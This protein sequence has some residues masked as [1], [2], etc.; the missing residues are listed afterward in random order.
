MEFWIEKWTYLALRSGMQDLSRALLMRF[1]KNHWQ[2]ARIDTDNYFQNFL[3]IVP[4]TK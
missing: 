3:K 1:Q 2:L 4:L